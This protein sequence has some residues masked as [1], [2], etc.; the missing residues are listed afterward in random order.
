LSRRSF[1]KSRLADVPLRKVLKRW[2][3]AKRSSM[4]SVRVP[5]SELALG[6]M[7]LFACTSAEAMGSYWAW[8]RRMPSPWRTG[9]SRC[10][11][12]PGLFSSAR[13]IASL[14]VTDS[15][16]SSWVIGKGT[17]S[18][19]LGGIWR[20]HC[21]ENSDAPHHVDDDG[22]GGAVH[23]ALPDAANNTVATSVRAAD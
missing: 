17:V 23:A 11:A 15:T 3:L 16:C 20:C 13:G 12:M 1:R 5:D 6:V 4:L 14:G 18:A 9:S 21:R 10:A 22:G 2:K 8:L 19:G 7:L